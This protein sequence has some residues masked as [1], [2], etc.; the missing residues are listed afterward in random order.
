[1]DI[2]IQQINLF[3]VSVPSNPKTPAALN[4]PDEANMACV[5]QL[6]NSMADLALLEDFAR[7]MRREHVFRDQL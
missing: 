3:K 6:I 7:G 2:Y 5:L 4:Y 1:M